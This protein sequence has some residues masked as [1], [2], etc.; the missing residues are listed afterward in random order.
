M[1]ERRVWVG[2]L[3]CYNEGRLNGEWMDPQDGPEWT[4]K[5]NTD[6]YPHE[7]TWVFDIEGF[8]ENRE[9]SPFEA[10]EL[11]AQLTD[12]EAYAES[13]GIPWEAVVAYRNEVGEGDV[14]NIA[15]AY[16]GEW[17][18]LEAWA[19]DFLT[20]TGTL[21]AIPEELRM[22]FDVAAWARDAAYDMHVL[23]A[24]DGGKYI[25]DAH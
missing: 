23:D 21:N 6:L 13:R 7:E 9:M 11:D 20:E 5:R 4:C 1:T 10:A 8:P 14:S 12:D 17:D 19:D 3:A 24:P 2:C 16:Y 25:F 15:D 22:Y 18:S